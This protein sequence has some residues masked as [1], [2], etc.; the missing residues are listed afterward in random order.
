MV[1]NILPT[2]DLKEHIESKH[3]EC[4]PTVRIVNKT[5]I[6]IHN[7]YDGREKIEQEI[8]EYI[9]AIRVY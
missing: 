4:K 3:C 6:I 9:K 5:T 1:W 7:S 2:N 8:D